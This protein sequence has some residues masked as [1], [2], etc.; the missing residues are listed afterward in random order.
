MMQGINHD[1]GIKQALCERQALCNCT[2]WQQTGFFLC[3]LEHTKGLVSN[4]D[5][6]GPLLESLRYPSGTSPRIE[7][8]GISW[9]IK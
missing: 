7:D 4:N 8:Q 5:L 9:N 6:V 1:D 3:F 2:I